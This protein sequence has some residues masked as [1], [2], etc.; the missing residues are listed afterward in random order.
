MHTGEY[1]ELLIG[2]NGHM[3]KITL[4]LKNNLEEDQYSNCVK[5]GWIE[6]RCG[7]N[8]SF[9]SWKRMWFILKDS[10]LTYYIKE[11]NL[12]KR[13]STI[14]STQEFFKQQHGIDNNNCTNSNSNN[15]NNNSDLIHLSAPSLSS[16]TSSTISP[17]SSSSSLTTTTTTTTTTTNANTNNGLSDSI[18][19]VYLEGE[20]GKKKEGKG[21][22]VRWMKLL[23]HSL[24]Y[25]KSSK[26]KEPLGIVNLNECQ[27]CEVNK[28]SSNKFV[29][30]H[31]SNRYY[32]KTN[33]KQE[34]TQWV[35]SVKS[36]IP[37][38]NQ[39]KMD[40]DQFQLKGVIE[41]NSIQQIAE[42]FKF[43]S[44][45]N[46]LTIT[47][48]EKAYYLSFDSNKDKLDWLNQ[49]NLTINK[50]KGG[51]NSGGGSNNSS[52]SSLQSQQAKE[53]GN[54]GSLS[55]NILGNF[56]SSIKPWRFSSSPSQGRVSIGGGGDRSST[57]VKF[58]DNP[59]SKSSNKEEFDGGEY[60]SQILPRKSTIIGPNGGVKVSTSGAVEL[61][62]VLISSNN[63]NNNTISSSGNS[64]PTCLS[65]LINESSDNEDGDDLKMMIPE[66]LK[67]EM[68]RRSAISS[69]KNFKLEIFIWSNHQE[70]FT[71]LFSD[72]V[73]VDQ[74]KAFA[75]KKIPSLANLSV[76]DYRLG[77]DEDTL[78]EVEFL[79][80]IYSH[81]MVELALKTCGIV[82]IGI[83]HHRKDRRVKEKL[84]SDKFYGHLL[85][86]SP[87]GRKGNG[88]GIGGNGIPI[89]Y[90]RSEPNLQSCLSSS[91]STRET[92][93]PSSPS[94]HQLITPPPSLKQYEQQLSS[95]SSSSSQQLQLQL[96]QQEQEQLLQEQPEAEQ[97][98]PEPQPQLEP[99]SEIEIEELEQP[100]EELLNISTTPISIRSNSILSSSTSASS[101]PSSTPS[102]TPVI[103]RQQKMSAAGW[104]SVNPSVTLNQRRQLISGCPGWNI[105]V[106]NPTSTFTSQG[107]KPK[108]DKQEH[109]FYRRYNF[110]GTSTV[111]SFLGVDM[112]MGP[113]A[114]SLAKDANDNYRGV[115]HT[116]HGA[117]TI[118]EDSKNIV[119][120]LNLL[121][122]SKKVKTKK[123]VSHL[124][125]LLD[126]SID[127]KLL[128]LAS[129]QSE[130][131]KEL[132]S[133]EER[134]TTSGF[135]FGMVYCR[136]GQ[137]TDDE[138]FSNK[139]GSPE[140]DEFLS[141]I[142]D[143]IELVGWPHYSAGLDVK[144]NSTGTHSLYTDYHGNEVMFHVST[145]LPF[146]TTDYQQIERKRQVGNDIC[147]VIF[148]DGTLSY[149]PNTI[150][151][152][153]NHVIILVQYDKQNNGYKV[154]MACK[155]GVKSPFEPLSPNNL[156]KKSDIKD[157]ILTKLINGE[158]ASLQAPV[159]ASKITRTR[160]SLLNYYISQFL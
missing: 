133:F 11:K 19:H 55:P 151:S 128:N 94:S 140:W 152:Q 71:F 34:L 46:C 120:I 93:V 121:S 63:N 86:Q 62:P 156:I 113:L 47:T 114:F 139:Q 52:P 21:W 146:S 127:A 129:N 119:G 126:P 77:I 101:S 51:F 14:G 81:T 72:S 87:D 58:V 70:V 12:K 91:P 153:F 4:K 106:S 56:K 84:Y 122:L 25:Y 8:Q 138:I 45:P 26:D 116:K 38:I 132:L 80:F 53:S 42:T 154:S 157:F 148:N 60:G 23:E 29:V 145:M 142:G 115:L 48:D 136:H 149:M 36:R 61:S 22:K 54:G 147:V 15:N 16:S 37:S 75:F 118:S 89:E 28:E 159:F 65:D 24:V 124:I 57:Q 31:S 44:Q 125:G 97:S 99:E 2:I 143:K 9:S 88:V 32:F 1:S 64:I 150:T 3:K 137:V 134:Q 144:F 123:V 82:K 6:K 69:L 117:K 111:Q 78:L 131:Q 104:H 85:S 130:L 90:S 67:N 160:E 68:M 108:F 66:S 98:Q 17:I 105:E 141:L 10:K 107:F 112:K 39:T 35:K 76:L 41:F 96:Q 73:L 50:F 100:I 33:T 40:L 92:M 103:E 95:S 74:V 20:L 13:S 158:L 109:G 7:K 43:N 18:N 5:Y 102:L 27:D 155:D 49:L 135:K 79:K 83:F 30:V 110:D 59:L